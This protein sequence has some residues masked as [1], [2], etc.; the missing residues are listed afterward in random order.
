VPGNEH[1]GVWSSPLLETVLGPEPRCEWTTAKNQAVGISLR[2]DV[3]LLVLVFDELRRSYGELPG[4]W[5]CDL[6]MP[7]VLAL[8]SSTTANPDRIS[9]VAC[10]IGE[11]ACD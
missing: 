11:I 1:Q 9:S 5:L 3:E 7:R 8:L 4:R 2:G 10:D 6:A